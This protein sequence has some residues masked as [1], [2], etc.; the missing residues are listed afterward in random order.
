MVIRQSWHRSAIVRV[1]VEASGDEVPQVGRDP[2]ICY[3]TGMNAPLV[4]TGPEVV[5][6]TTADY[7]LLADAGAF[8]GHHRTELIDGAVYAVSPLYRPHGFVRDELAYLMRRTLEVLGSEY[9]VSTEASVDMA[10]ISEPLPDIIVT[11]AR[12]G[13]G[14]IPLGSVA[15]LVEVSSNTLRFD[16]ETKAQVYA[17]S[18]VPEYWVVDVG[19]GAVHRMWA[20]AP[21]GYAERDEVRLGGRLESVTLPGLGVD[22][23]GLV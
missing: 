11:N 21:D 8:V 20:A 16:L 15:L 18:G 2:A 23:A 14:A 13:E 6:L 12:R 5:K 9:S 4:V 10:P 19:G 3:A 7:H 1:N 17:A 22:T